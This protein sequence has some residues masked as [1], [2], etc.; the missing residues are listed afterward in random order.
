MTNYPFSYT[1]V[2]YLGGVGE[3]EY[4]LESGMGLAGSFADAAG[5]IENYYGSDLVS[6]K[7]LCLH[8]ENDLIILHRED[9][10]A[11]AERE[12]KGDYQSV[13]IPCNYQGIPV[14][15]CGVDAND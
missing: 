8:E 7:E 2:V 13:Q 4:V 6:I 3:H 15:D 10:V 5:T 1:A 9:I 11:Y 14:P 12:D